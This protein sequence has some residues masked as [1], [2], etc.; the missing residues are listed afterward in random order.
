MWRRH[1]S[2]SPAPPRHDGGTVLQDVK[3]ER[4][5]R[6]PNEGAMTID[7]R[8]F[9][10]SAPGGDGTLEMQV[11]LA[12]SDRG[13]GTDASAYAATVRAISAC[14]SGRRP[15]QARRIKP[16]LVGCLAETGD[17]RPEVV[18]AVVD[19]ALADEA[20]ALSRLLRRC[21]FRAVDTDS[22]ALILSGRVR[23]VDLNASRSCSHHPG[24]LAY[25][26]MLPDVL[27]RNDIVRQRGQARTRE[28]L[29]S[30]RRRISSASRRGQLPVAVG[31]DG[32]FAAQ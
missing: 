32:A 31:A 22:S 25:P 12:S 6:K 13:R 8:S 11:L 19:P 17:D 1:C 28:T 2:T 30:C 16:N 23:L 21:A 15:I 29:V 5:R 27:L 14:G 7:R 18:R 10:G 4:L 20:A 26:A 9:H 3:S 24:G